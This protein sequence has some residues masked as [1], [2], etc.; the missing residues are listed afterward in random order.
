MN[1]IVCANFENARVFEEG[2]AQFTHL[3]KIRGDLKVT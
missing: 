3:E 2:T 1:S